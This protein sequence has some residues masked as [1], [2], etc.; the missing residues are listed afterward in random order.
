L[1]PDCHVAWAV[2]FCYQMQ[3]KVAFESHTCKEPFTRA[4]LPGCRVCRE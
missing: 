3:L 4:N 1:F 2:P